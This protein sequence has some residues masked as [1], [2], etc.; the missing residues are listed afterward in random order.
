MQGAGTI[1]PLVV[2]VFGAFGVN[3]GGADVAG[4]VGCDGAEGGGG[5]HDCG[6]W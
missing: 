6:E 1:D 5:R 4:L 3:R 2:M